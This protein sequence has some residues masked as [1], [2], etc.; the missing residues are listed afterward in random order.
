MGHSL[1]GL[2]AKNPPERMLGPAP[3]HLATK[4]AMPIFDCLVT[5]VIKVKVK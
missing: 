1:Y 4:I 2:S 3:V 5:T